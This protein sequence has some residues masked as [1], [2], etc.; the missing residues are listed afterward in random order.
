MTPHEP[1]QP[2][3]TTVL[4]PRCAAVYGCTGRAVAEFGG[5]PAHLSPGE[6]DLFVEGIRPGA[7]LDLRGV[8]VPAWL[9]DALLD[10]LSGPDGRPHIGRTRFDGAVLP[11]HAVLH[12]A[13]VEGDS[14]FDGACFLGGASFYDAR[15]FGNVSFRGARFGGNVSFHAARFHRHASFEEAV[16]A[17]DA[18]FGEANWHADAS[19][20]STVFIGAACFDR[21]RFGRDAA[22]QAACFGAAASFKRVHVT[23]H[24]RFER[25]RFRRGLWLG[26]LVAGGQIV[27]AD[28][29]AH[30]GLR[31]HA[32]APQVTARGLTVRGAAE[33]RLRHA[34]LDLERADIGGTVTVRSLPQPI[35]GLTEPEWTGPAAIRLLSLRE[36]ASGGLHLSDVD[37]SGC[38]FLGLQHPDLL[39]VSGDCPFA[40]LPTRQRWWSRHHEPDHSAN[41]RPG[42]THAGRTLSGRGRY[43]RARARWAQRGRGRAVLAED[44]ARRS[45]DGADDDTDRLETLYR[46]LARAIA[47]CGHHALARDFRYSALEMRRHS[48]PDQ[49]RRWLLHILWL[50]SGYGLRAGRL[51]AWIA[52]IV[53]LVCCG[54]TYLR[55]NGH[56]STARPPVRQPSASPGRRPL[57]TV[58]AAPVFLGHRAPPRS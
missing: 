29:C 15:F 56:E 41:P 24:A 48:E 8:T 42:H 6:F 10:A 35:A 19:F 5:C 28:A 32:A 49:W 25:A 23:R 38:A 47:G 33:F 58:I 4:W 2:P 30:A 12:G 53:A 9:L 18:L 11:S 37:L 27:L 26:P 34:E 39:R 36:V 22:M 45:G 43:G 50:T 57:P 14:S 7:D 52:V 54:V 13:C 3:L 17:G 55:H 16:F 40:T 21:A 46:E 51:M 20:R 31:V 1:S 44:L